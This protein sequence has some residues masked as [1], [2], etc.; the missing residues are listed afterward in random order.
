MVT[1]APIFDGVL[2]TLISA[3]LFNDIASAIVLGVVLFSGAGCI[4]VALSI[5][6]CLKIKIYKISLVYSI[7]SIISLL[8]AA[9]TEFIRHIIFPHFYIFSSL[10]LIVLRAEFL[11]ANLRIKSIEVIKIS[12]AVL[13]IY[14]VKNL[15]DKFY[16]NIETTSMLNVLISLLAGYTTTCL[17]V[18]ILSKTEKIMDLRIFRKLSGVILIIM[19]IKLLL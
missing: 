6:A 9:A 18:F 14:S 19:G 2:F 15:P 5:K 11:G 7:V 4:S 16:L 1:S 8:T 13:I 12:L 10:L 17:S 3:G